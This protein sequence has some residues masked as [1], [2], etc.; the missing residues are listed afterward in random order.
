MLS[1]LVSVT[2][3]AWALSSSGLSLGRAHCRNQPGDPGYPT[4]AD[5]S[6]FNNTIDGRLLNVVP[7]AEACLKLGCTE[8]QWSSGIFRQAIPGSMNA[9]NWEQDYGP[10]AELCLQN[11]TTCEQGFVPLYAVNATAAQH[12]QAGIRFA[13]AHNL[14]VAIKSSG[15]DYLGRS[16]AK[17]SLLLWTAYFQNI[18]FTEHFLVA[19]VDQ[20]PSVTV[21][22]GVGLKTLYAAAK[23]QN[24]V[25]IGGTAAT[26]SAAGG[27]TQGA[28]HSAF[29]PIYGLASD[30]VLQY[31]VVLANGSF[32]TVNAASHPDLFWALRGGGA[33][34]WGV[35][36]DATLRTVP[37]FNITLHTVNI[38]TDSL[39]QTGDLMTAHAS[40]I[41]DWD[42][43]R[44]GQYFYL[45]GS[46]TNS[47]LVVNTVF[48]DLDGAS[49]KA[50]LSSFLSSATA[51]GAVVQ[52]ETTITAPPNDIVGFA[53]DPSG[54][55]VILSSRLIPNSVY[56]LAPNSVGA[57]YKRLLSQGVQTV[58][59]HLVAGGVAANANI[60]SAV[61]PAWRTAKTHV[62]ATARWGNTV[63][64]A[65]VR[66]LRKNFT[67]TVR[68]VLSELAGGA[69]SGSYSNEGDVLEPDFSVTFYGPN[70]SRL[71]RIKAVYDPND[72]FIV[73]TGVRSEH[74]DA[75]GMCKI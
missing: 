13:Q 52:G 29:S 41:K 36:I 74:W 5:W 40:H 11:G 62:I 28:G 59:G 23:A 39:N 31:S 19:D 50:Q 25:F 4:S 43:V 17:N 55:N 72:L 60:E 6:A 14:R 49:S 12:I 61:H 10:P 71:E 7:S 64:A 44:A 53:D 9:Y 75:D 65:D 66:A 54:F 51:L 56:L 18:S 46:T 38:L 69:S 47:A 34:S 3:V 20:G 67:A 16:T 33:G 57:A 22:S 15:H 30:N 58:L 24:K 63:S 26:V 32:V 2:A 42:G 48:K 45:A 27:Y 8:A 73:S 35:I 70:Y 37:S 68:P 1:F 21:G